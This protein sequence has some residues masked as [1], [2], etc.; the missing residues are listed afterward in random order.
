MLVLY[1]LQKRTG[2]TWRGNWSEGN[3]GAEINS[4]KNLSGTMIGRSAADAITLTAQSI[5][6]KLTSN[7]DIAR[8]KHTEFRLPLGRRSI[9]RCSAC[10]HLLV[11]PK[12]HR[13]PNYISREWHQMSPLQ[14]RD[15]SIIAVRLGR[16]ISRALRK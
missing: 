15:K 11:N 16:R 14:K 12:Y 6:R 1:S 4:S 3:S 8:G 13:Y 7:S 10:V 2:V 5:A 9:L